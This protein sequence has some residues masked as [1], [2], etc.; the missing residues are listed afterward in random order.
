MGSGILVGDDRKHL[1]ALLGMDEKKMEW[2]FLEKVEQFNKTFYRPKLMRKEGMPY[3]RCI[4]LDKK[5]MCKV[6]DAKPLQCKIAMGCRS[7]GEDISLWFLLNYLLDNGDPEAIRQ[8]KL[9]LD[10][11]GKTLPGG[12]LARLVGPK[13]RLKTMLDYASR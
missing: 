12:S 6:H 7:Y 9:Y 10:A 3:G 2:R 13:K 4:F 8:F 1:A 5:G 11:G